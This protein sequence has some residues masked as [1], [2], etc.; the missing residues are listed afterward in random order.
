MARKDDAMTFPITRRA[1]LVCA[2]VAIGLALATV[3]ALVALAVA[4]P[5]SAAPATRLV[6]PSIG[7]DSWVVQDYGNV[8]KKP[9]PNYVAQYMRGYNQYVA[10]GAPGT[11]ILGGH[12]VSLWEGAVFQRLSEVLVGDA[13]LLDG[14]RYEGACI[15]GV[16]NT[17]ANWEA[18]FDPEYCVVAP[19]DTA[20]YWVPW[21]V[22][23]REM[24]ATVRLV[25]CVNQGSHY[26]VVT[27]VLQ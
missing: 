12:D 21:P 5:A 4:L 23:E 9:I 1:V 27:G 24:L 8:F 18:L 15:E 11:I 20:G 16:V 17:L 10:P 3:A 26:F 6:V 19:P 7:V 25:T 14:Y 22:V 2:A 13:I